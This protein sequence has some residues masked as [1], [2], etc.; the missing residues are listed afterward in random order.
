[1]AN[2]YT[3]FSEQIDGLSPEAEKWAHKLLGI[4]PDD[5]EEEDLAF[6]KAELGEVDDLDCW[7]AFGWEIE[8]H[9]KDSGDTHSIWLYSDEGCD[10]NHVV[11]FVQ[12]LIRKFMPDYIFSLTHAETCS[13]LRLGEFGGGWM[14]VSKDDVLCGS[15]WDAAESAVESLKKEGT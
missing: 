7:P 11:A 13:K 5:C 14:V 15:T 10:Y 2:N 3:Q 1:M 9:L 8:S 6:L 4:S 12:A